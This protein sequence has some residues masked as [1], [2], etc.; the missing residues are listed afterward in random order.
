MSHSSIYFPA[1]TGWCFLK[2]PRA[3]L[4]NPEL[5]VRASE[6][7]VLLLLILYLSSTVTP[8]PFQDH[9]P[10]AQ[11]QTFLLFFTCFLTCAYNKPW[12]TCCYF[13]LINEETKSQ[14]GQVNVAARIE[15]KV[16]VI[17]RPTLL[18]LLSWKIIP[19]MF[20]ST[21]L[22]LIFKYFYKRNTL[23]F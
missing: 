4:S 20:S 17:P 5:A 11:Q 7:S 22:L 3:L 1:H 18:P 2:G 21:N 12:G 13:H 14:G 23:F 19:W 6:G 8:A 16:G 9:P 10:H 15:G